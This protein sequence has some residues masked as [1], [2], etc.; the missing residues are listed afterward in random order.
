MFRTNITVSSNL[1]RKLAAAIQNYPSQL[2]AV[3]D[4]T[5]GAHARSTHK[6]KNR[7][8]KLE[9][10]TKAYLVSANFGSVRVVLEARRPYARYVARH[11]Y[12]S[13]R[14]AGR[15]ARAAVSRFNRMLLR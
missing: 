15:I 11:G 1:R 13:L 3:V 5:G 10:S 2:R 12:L 7:S 14:E 4:S 8:G 6:Y 9:E